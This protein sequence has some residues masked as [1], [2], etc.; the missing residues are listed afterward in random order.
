MQWSIGL[1]SNGYAKSFHPHRHHASQMSRQ[2]LYLD[3]NK[4][5]LLLKEHINGVDGDDSTLSRLRELVVEGEIVC[6][7]SL[8]HLIETSSYSNKESVDEMFNLMLDLSLNQTVAPLPVVR[9]EEIWKEVDEFLSRGSSMEGKVFGDGLA[10]ALGGRHYDVV[11]ESGEMGDKKRREIL[12][13]I[14]SEW[15]TKEYLDL[16]D[17]RETFGSREHEQESIK[18]FEEGRMENEERFNDN[19]RRRKHE[20]F[21]YFKEFVIPEVIQKQTQEL[22]KMPD[23][24]L[25]DILDHDIEMERLES[26]EYAWEWIQA[27]PA[28]YT[29][30][31]LTSER[32]LQ[33]DRDIKGNDLNDIMALSVAIPYCDMVVTENFWTHLSQQVGLDELYGTNVTTD[34]EDVFDLVA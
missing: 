15:A 8:I 30:V 28:V 33:K 6:P 26:E 19:S 9:D 4:W 23:D 24:K 25:F 12:D 3:Q 1:C 21:G 11:A 22:A 27:F 32:D 18:K 7:L 16:Q 31:S 13:T 34:I 20:V 10:F 29:Y 14:E 17:V 2:R 5:I